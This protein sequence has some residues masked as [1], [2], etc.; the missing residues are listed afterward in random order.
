M[1]SFWSIFKARKSN[2]GSESER[3][4]KVKKVLTKEIE[5][6]V[7]R[8]AAVMA[9]SRSMVV[10]TVSVGDREFRALPR[11]KGKGLVL[12]ESDEGFRQS[13]ASKIVQEHSPLS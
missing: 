4:W 2:R 8:N 1:R 13:K 7:S 10:T 12:F 9:R 6:D 5:G 3:Y 11:S